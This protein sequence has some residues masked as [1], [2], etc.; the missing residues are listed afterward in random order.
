MTQG[1]RPAIPNERIEELR[2]DFAAVDD[3]QDGRIDF[4]EFTVLMNELGA[5]MSSEV[6]R[7]GFGEIDTDRDGRISLAEFV[8]WRTQ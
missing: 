6:L 5:E 2:E 1:N 8:A 3:D 4:A 7:I